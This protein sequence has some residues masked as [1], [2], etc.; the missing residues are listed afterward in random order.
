MGKDRK[1]RKWMKRVKK[2]EKG[3]VEDR[4]EGGEVKR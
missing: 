4:V 1:A 3:E 2:G